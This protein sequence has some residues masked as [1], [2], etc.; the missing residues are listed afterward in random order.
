MCKPRSVGNSP[1]PHDQSE[2]AEEASDLW[3][4]AGILWHDR[5]L[6]IW[7]T[8]V[9]TS[10]AVVFLVISLLLAPDMSPLPNIYRASA[11]VL[12]DEESGTTAQRSVSLGGIE[13]PVPSTGP[14]HGALAETL[15]ETKSTIDLIADE[16]ELIARYR[17]T[18][19]GR[20]RVREAFRKHGTFDF[21]LET[22]TLTIAYEDY[23]PTFAAGVVNRLV[24]ILEQRFATIQGDHSRRRRDL[25]AVRYAEVEHQI[26]R[27]ATRIKEFQHRYGILDVDTLAQEQVR[28]IA[29]V[30]HQIM[31]KEMQIQNY[32]QVARINDPALALL[33]V[34][35]ENL[36]QL[37][38]EME[39][40]FSEFERVFPAQSEIPDLAMEFAQLRLELAVQ[41]EIYMILSQQYELA[42]LEVE[43]QEP[44]LQ[45]LELADVPDL[46]AGPARSQIAVLSLLV[47]LGAAIVVALLRNSL[48]RHWDRRRSERRASGAGQEELGADA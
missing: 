7:I 47:T 24:A 18:K 16:F 12:I 17:I 11:L 3:T 19:P 46:K 40:G 13:L 33:Q 1:T 10:I 38:A 23:D 31:V 42:K 43:G 30:G 14:Q 44:I 22:G 36:M 2:Y 32:S 4:I 9:G 15:L 27:Y 25:L 28:R 41:T 37:L 35:R 39:S 45:V 5:R 8:T 26:I 20:G 34:E 48:R 29:D 6:I 21:D